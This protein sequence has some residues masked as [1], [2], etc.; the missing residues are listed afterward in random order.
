MVNE[1][2]V[3]GVSHVFCLV[4]EGIN[5][6]YVISSAWAFDEGALE[7]V[8]DIGICHEEHKA[9][10]E[11][12]SEKFA[13]ATCDGYGA[14]ICW[15]VFGAFFVEGGNIG[16]LPRGGEIGRIPYRWLNRFVRKVRQLEP[17]HFSISFEMWSRPVALPLVSFLRWESISVGVM[18]S[19]MGRL[20]VSGEGG[21]VLKW[22]VHENARCGLDW[23]SDR[24]L[25]SLYRVRKKVVRSSSLTYWSGSSHLA[26][27]LRS[28]SKFHHSVGDLLVVECILPCSICLNLLALDLRWRR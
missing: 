13:K 21:L 7:G 20:H 16:I 2:H 14:V 23:E 26:F 3:E 15:V 5:H 17:V 9:G 19:S 24:R 25:G 28:R 18:S 1:C 12:S 8:G 4:N 10:V 6:K 11:V 27:D 22:S